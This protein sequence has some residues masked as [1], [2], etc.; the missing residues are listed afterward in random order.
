MFD[1]SPFNK[2]TPWRNGNASD[3]RPED[4]GFDSLWGQIFG[5]EPNNKGRI[6]QSVERWSNKPLV[7]G[8][9]PIVPILFFWAS[10]FFVFFFFLVDGKNMRGPG[11]EPGSTAWKAAM[12]TITPATLLST[13]RYGQVARQPLRKR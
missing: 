13:S 2:L 1:F 3:S 11:I 9:I 6:A 12:L 5:V 4:W 10:F 7:M 8:S